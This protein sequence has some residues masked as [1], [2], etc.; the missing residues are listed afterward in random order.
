MAYIHVKIDENS[1]AKLTLL[2]LDG[3]QNVIIN[4]EKY[5]EVTSGNHVIELYGPDTDYVFRGKL[6]EDGVWEVAAMLG[7]RSLLHNG[8]SFFP[9]VF[10]PEQYIR[11]LNADE[12]KTIKEIMAAEQRQAE[13]KKEREDARG[14]AGLQ[15][16]LAVFTFA[17]A[18]ACFIYVFYDF[19]TSD[20][21]MCAFG[22]IGF[23]ALFVFLV[24][25][26]IKNFRK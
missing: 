11:P 16:F 3:W 10:E 13:I 1:P 17:V 21:T 9:V 6:N 5:I 15:I 12:M 14:I 4:G 2:R 8:N 19:G 7:L 23:S 25:K 18:L 26:A 22:A 20:A 24:K